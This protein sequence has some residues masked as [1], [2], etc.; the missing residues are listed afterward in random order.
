MLPMVTVTDYDMVNFLMLLTFFLTGTA[1]GKR[2]S[3]EWSLDLRVSKMEDTSIVFEH[4]DL[5]NTLDAIH[6]KFV[7]WTLVR[8]MNEN[9]H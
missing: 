2:I 7:Q 4:V 9:M 5:F 1:N 3:C 6:I 8:C